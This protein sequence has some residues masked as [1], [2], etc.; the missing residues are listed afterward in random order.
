METISR[1]IVSLVYYNSLVRDTLEYTSPK[2]K[3]EVNFYDYKRNGI[4]NEP[5]LNTPLKVFLDQNGEKADELRKRL[6]Q[7]GEDFYSDNSTVVKKAA[8]GTLRVDHAQNVKI[9]ES[10]IPLHEELNSIIN[11]HV[12]F[13]RNNNQLEDRVVKLVEADE[14]FYRGVALF[15]LQGELVRQF[16][17]FNK[18]M[19]ESQGQATPQSNFI[20]NDLNSLVKALNTVRQNATVKDNVYI[21]ALDAVFAEVE[22]MNGRRD[23]PAGKNFADVFNDANVKISDLVKEAE[24]AWRINYTPLLQELIA[25]SQK[26]QQAQAEA[27]PEEEKKAE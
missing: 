15:A 12:N 13:A 24:E 21:A 10:V 18:V 19:R 2:D 23:L 7:F 16:E 9:F 27:K 17:E 26:A 22:M 4:V 5:K 8:D 20:Q 1:V 11:L 25:D 6:E 3:Y 14:R